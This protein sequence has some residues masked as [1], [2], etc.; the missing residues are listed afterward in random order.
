M[1]LKEENKRLKDTQE[2]QNQ[3]LNEDLQELM[4]EKDE[5]VKNMAIQLEHLQKNIN[6][7]ETQ[8]EELEKTRQS[9][10]STGT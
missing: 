10:L 2:K 9:G 8:V 4:H 6:K 5:T 7:L 1:Q 3:K